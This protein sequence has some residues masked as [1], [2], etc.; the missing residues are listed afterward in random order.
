MGKRVLVVRFSAI[1][2]LLLTAPVLQA[3]SE[4]GYEVT[5]LVKV[6]YKGAAEV[7]PGVDRILTW[8]WD[9]L[10]LLEDAKN[11]FDVLVDLQGTWQSKHFAKTLNLPTY[12]FHKPYLRRF[13]LLRTKRH[14]FALPHV[15]DR[16]FEAASELL[17]QPLVPSTITFKAPKKACVEGKIVFVIGGSSPG[18]RLSVNQ[19]LELLA[20][21]PEL[22]SRIALIGGPSDQPLA[23]ALQAHY[24]E[25]K[26][27][28]KVTIATCVAM[29]RDAALVVSGDTGF[30]HAAAL[31]GT[32]LISLW[33]A[34]HPDLG[35]G[36]WPANDNQELIY[37][38]SR[39]MPLSKHGKLVPFL[40][41]PMDKIDTSE[42]ASAIAQK[43]QGKT[44]P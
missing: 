18:K 42:I 37:T 4:A 3:L 14:Q 36:P 34:T 1:G 10:T 31:Q 21:F 23:K 24:P 6:S 28:T 40:P 35:F 39:L 43:L 16:Y 12:T 30:M 20:N 44:T 9:Q 13:L 7:L 25:L 38:K 26:D 11:D 32:P 19:W 8:E 33:A 2:D 5:L 41:N 17:N 22:T 29:V 27:A 15:V